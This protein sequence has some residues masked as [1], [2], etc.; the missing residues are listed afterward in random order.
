MMMGGGGCQHALSG[1]NMGEWDRG[2]M[3]NRLGRLRP[4]MVAISGPSRNLLPQILY[5]WCL[6]LHEPLLPSLVSPADPDH[7]GG[8]E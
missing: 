8:P 6:P 3:E 7:E 1:L 4:T 2:E 5:P